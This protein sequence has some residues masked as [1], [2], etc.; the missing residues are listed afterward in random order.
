MSCCFSS[1]RHFV[2]LITRVHSGVLKSICLVVTA[3]SAILTQL[4]M[5]DMTAPQKRCLLHVSRW[6]ADQPK[7]Y[8]SGNFC[9]SVI[10]SRSHHAA[11]CSSV[12]LSDK[13][14]CN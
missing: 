13:F 11:V 8:T 12:Y 6:D 1:Q 10:L 7:Q 2:V 4:K 5:E 9:F 14:G 3:R